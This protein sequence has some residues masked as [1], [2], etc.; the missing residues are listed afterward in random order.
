VD[1]VFTNV[2]LVTLTATASTGALL[3][4]ASHFGWT[5]NFSRH[6]A[7]RSTDALT[8]LVAHYDQ[9]F[10]MTDENFVFFISNQT[11]R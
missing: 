3:V 2:A 1:D 9:Q 7:A 4:T 10:N 11:K 8:A 6:H 5:A